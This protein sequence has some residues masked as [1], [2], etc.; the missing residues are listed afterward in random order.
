M[1]GHSLLPTYQP[2]AKYSG[3]LFGVEY[4]H[5]QSGEVFKPDLDTDVENG[6]DGVQDEGFQEGPEIG[7]T[8]I[9]SFCTP[10]PPPESSSDEV[11][12]FKYVCSV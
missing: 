1:L 6:L 11:R 9:D 5:A 3:E 8:D 4:L 2:P 7:G 10:P 12:I